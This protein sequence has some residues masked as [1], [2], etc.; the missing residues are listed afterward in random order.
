[1]YLGCAWLFRRRY[2]FDFRLRSEATEDYV[3]V[4][5]I[6]VKGYSDL[7]SGRAETLN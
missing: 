2:S 3:F 4:T 6:S 1:M 7:N 5:R